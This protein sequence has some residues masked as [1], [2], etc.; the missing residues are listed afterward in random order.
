MALRDAKHCWQLASKPSDEH[1]QARLLVAGKRAGGLDAMQERNKE[2]HAAP[3]HRGADNG[4]VP[5]GQADQEVVDV[6]RTR[7]SLDLIARGGAA[8]QRLAE[9]DV[10]C[11]RDAEE[12]RFLVHDADALTQVQQVPLLDGDAVQQDH[13]GVHVVEAH[14]LRQRNRGKEGDQQMS[15]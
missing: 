2:T 3:T 6:G 10:V 9:R 13:A 4:V 8:G 7:C 11:D 5:V 1:W 15:A 12:R 14:E